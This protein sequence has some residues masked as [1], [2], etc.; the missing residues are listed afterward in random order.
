VAAN[1][2]RLRKRLGVSQESL[3]ARA[4]IDRTYLSSCE[5]GRRNVSVDN[6]Y[7][8]ASALNA[9]VRELFDTSKLKDG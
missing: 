5:R 6:I 3:A 8:L 1:L 7:R 9:D 4:G 2:R